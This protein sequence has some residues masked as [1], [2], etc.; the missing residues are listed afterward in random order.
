M[1]QAGNRAENILMP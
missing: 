1:G